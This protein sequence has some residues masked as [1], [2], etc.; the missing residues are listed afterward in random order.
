M[1]FEIELTEIFCVQGDINAPAT[2]GAWD[3]ADAILTIRKSVSALQRHKFVN[4]VPAGR[5]KLFRTD[6]KFDADSGIVS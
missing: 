2:F 3:S 4:L 5:Y 1:G 6:M